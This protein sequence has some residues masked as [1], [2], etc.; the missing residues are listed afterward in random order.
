MSSRL[1]YANSLLFG[2]TQKN[3]SWLQHVQNTLAGVIAGYHGTISS[4]ILQ[5]LH[6][7]PINQCIKFKLA[8]LTH[9]TLTSSQPAY[10]SSLFLATTSLHVLYA[11]PTPICCRFLRSTQPLLSV[12]SAL[13]P[14]QYG[15]HYL[16]AS[17]LACHH[18]HSVVFLNPL[19]RPGLQFP[20][21]AHTDASDSTIWQTLHFKGFY[22][23]TYLCHL[24]LWMSHIYILKLG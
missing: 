21:A 18:I 22:L 16:L 15:T 3:I 2:T 7:L 10:L 19:F 1:D 5:H 24:G 17:A 12:V 13:L 11:P 20:L 14:P 23:L 8:T 4:A 9:N 6:W